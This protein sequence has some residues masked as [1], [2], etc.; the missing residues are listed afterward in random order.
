VKERLPHDG[1]RILID[2]FGSVL[3]DTDI[4]R[5]SIVLAS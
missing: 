4:A 1:P 5:R 2:A 3:V